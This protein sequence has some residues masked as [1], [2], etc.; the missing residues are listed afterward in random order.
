MFTASKNLS[1]SFSSSLPPS[2]CPS[3]PLSLFLS[4]S[5]SVFPSPPLPP[6]PSLLTADGSQKRPRTTISQKQLEILKTAYCISP[7][8]SRHVR[9]EL[10]DKTGLDMRVVQVWFQN[11]RAKDKR[12]KKD[13]GSEEGAGEGEGRGGGEGDFGVA[14][15]TSATEDIQGQFILEPGKVWPSGYYYYL[16]IGYYRY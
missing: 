16:N 15:P 10:S 9:Q 4:L 2:L 12:T 1:L 7:K 8:P 11:K 14:T 13:D 3:F 5:P 6:S